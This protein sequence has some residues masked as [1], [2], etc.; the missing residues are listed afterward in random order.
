MASISD[1]EV[2][3]AG[4]EIPN[5]SRKENESIKQRITFGSDIKFEIYLCILHFNASFA[6]WER[7]PQKQPLLLRLLTFGDTTIGMG[8]RHYHS[9]DLDTRD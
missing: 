6:S 7:C 1:D 4:F 3:N 9:N 5:C 8:V 2:L